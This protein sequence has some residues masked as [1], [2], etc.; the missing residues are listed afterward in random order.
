LGKLFWANYFGHHLL[1]YI[2][3]VAWAFAPKNKRPHMLSGGTTTC[4]FRGIPG[5]AKS[6]PLHQARLQHFWTS[7]GLS[8]SLLSKLFVKYFQ[9]SR[10]AFDMRLTVDGKASVP[11]IELTDAQKRDEAETLE[12]CKLMDKVTQVLRRFQMCSRW[13]DEYLDMHPEM[14]SE[15]EASLVRL[16]ALWMQR[17]EEE[18]AE[19]GD[20]ITKLKKEYGADLKV[21]SFELGVQPSLAVCSRNDAHDA[22]RDKFACILRTLTALEAK[23]LQAPS[24]ADAEEAVDDEADWENDFTEAD[25]YA[26]DSYSMY[27]SGSKY[28][29]KMKAW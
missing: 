25:Y 29:G 8:Q 12:A 18:E 9:G 28:A 24:P 3:S 21:P 5:S 4:E 14:V 2:V 11:E 10:F 26:Y 20:F 15:V 23:L 22:A 13:H 7:C 27:T 17:C 19:T 6:V 1:G 16:R